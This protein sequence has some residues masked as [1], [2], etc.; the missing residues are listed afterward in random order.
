MLVTR[1]AAQAGDLVAAI[2]SAGGRAIRFPVIEIVPVDATTAKHTADTL[3]AADI[4]IFVSRNA[5]VHGGQYADDGLIAAIGPGTAN[6]LADEGQTVAIVPESGFDSESLLKETALQ[7]V[8]GKNIRIIRGTDGREYLADQLRARG[9]NVDYLPVYERIAAKPSRAELAA[10]ESQWQHGDIH[11]VVVMSVATLR[12]LR[13]LLPERCA[14]ALG[15]T[16]LV[17]PATRVIKDCLEYY[18]ASRPELASGT[19][20]AAIVQALAR[21]ASERRPEADST[22]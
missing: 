21:I 1:P 17:T 4:S 15:N 6:A 19:D 13:Q 11:A 18:P 20:A 5:V 10:L 12:N 7:D 2:E 14:G 3:P 9:A 22:R 8:A 16:P